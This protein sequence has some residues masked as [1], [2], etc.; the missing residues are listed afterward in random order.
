MNRKDP[1]RK[2]KQELLRNVKGIGPVT[3]STL[4]ADLPELGK[5]NKKEIAALSGLLPSTMTA[6]NGA[7]HVYPRRP[8][9]RTPGLDMAAVAATRSNPV[10]HSFYQSLLNVRKTEESRPRRLHA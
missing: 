1:E 3:A 10:I 5:I 7:L 8:P 9:S 4:S 2:H 6:V